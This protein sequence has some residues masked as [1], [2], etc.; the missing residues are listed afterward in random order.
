[1]KVLI[2][3]CAVLGAFAGFGGWGTADAATASVNV[4]DNAYSP[5]SI[6]ITVGD[7]V[8]WTWTGANQHT[9]SSDTSE[10]FD[11]GAP[12]TS[13]TFSHTFNGA[14]T[15][16][17]LCG[18]HGQAMTGTVI[19]QAAAPTNT[20]APATNTAVAAT[21]TPRP[22]D[23]PD[24]ATSTPRPATATPV[25]SASAVATLPVAAP[26]AT[27]AV[28]GAPAAPTRA[29]EG[30]VLP[31]SGDGTGGG[32]GDGRWLALA[33]LLVAGVALS[34]WGVKRRA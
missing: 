21:N 14:G 15:F 11:S 30:A 33:G 19:V 13:G 18:V 23:T 20:P 3:A 6:A 22:T 29:A 25:G 9:V 31:R 10:A 26:S 27:V 28:S 1:M 24:G 16:T 17:Y 12:M 32:G 2:V 4:T 7:T 8:Q 5:S 34:W